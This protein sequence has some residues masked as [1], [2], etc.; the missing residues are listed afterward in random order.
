MQNSFAVNIGNVLEGWSEHVAKL[1]ATTENRQ[2]GVL[3]S[4]P[5]RVVNNSSTRTRLSM[6]FF[7]EPSLEAQMPQGVVLLRNGKDPVS[8]YGE[9][10]FRTYADSY[11]D[12]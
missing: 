2:I 8:T 5:H 9:H 1:V 3:R 7:L 11:P 12:V 10:I 4:T 6:P